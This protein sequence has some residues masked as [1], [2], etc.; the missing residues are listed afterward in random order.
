MRIAL[1]RGFAA[2]AMQIAKDAAPY[3]DAKLV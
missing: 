1:K 3:F 2:E